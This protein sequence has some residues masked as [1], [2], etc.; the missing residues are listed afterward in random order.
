MKTKPL[1]LLLVLASIAFAVLMPPE[2]FPAGRM[3]VLVCATFGFLAC[4][5]DKRVSN[6]FLGAGLITFAALLAHSIFFSVDLYRSL[7]FLT[8]LW[9]YYCL[10]GFFLYSGHAMI[11]PAAVVM[12]A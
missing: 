9:T 12:V 8:L 4:L 11:T 2:A 6:G 5:I 1:V 3:A 7:E 10:L